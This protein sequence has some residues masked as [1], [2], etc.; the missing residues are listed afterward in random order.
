MAKLSGL[1]LEIT[2][3]ANFTK[4][5]IFTFSNCFQSHMISIVRFIKPW[6]PSHEHMHNYCA[7]MMTGVFCHAVTRKL[8]K[9]RFKITSSCSLS[10][11]STS[12]VGGTP[13]CQS[14]HHETSHG[15]TQRRRLE[16]SRLWSMWQNNSKAQ[17]DCDHIRGNCV[18]DRME[19]HKI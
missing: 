10:I 4:W 14:S 2:A 19:R 13:A 12:S 3:T 5:N 9:W 18:N 8:S 11:P 7:V 6:H 15:I 17:Y 1:I 16:I